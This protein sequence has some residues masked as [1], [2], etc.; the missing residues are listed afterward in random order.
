MILRGVAPTIVATV[1]GPAGYPRG[2]IV[3][4]PL[5]VPPASSASAARRTP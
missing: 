4:D 5:G 1:L 3:S 2:A